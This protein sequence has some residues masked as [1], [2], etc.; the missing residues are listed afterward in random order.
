MLL[1]LKSDLRNKKSCIELLKTQ[2]LTPVTTAQGQALAKR[3]GALYMECSSKEKIGVEEIFDR[4]VIEA[5]GDEWRPKTR[6]QRPVTN[7]SNNDLSSKPMIKKKKKPG[8]C[9]TF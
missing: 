3:M 9:K 4:A 8:I 1:G 5:V 7:Q 6:T 2:G